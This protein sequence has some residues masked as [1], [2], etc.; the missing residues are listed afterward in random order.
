[1]GGADT[2][3]HAGKPNYAQW[4]LW[5]GVEG[6]NVTGVDYDFD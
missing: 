1:M 3:F 6:M 2:D 4:K 5:R